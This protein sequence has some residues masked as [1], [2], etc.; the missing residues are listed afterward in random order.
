M[1]AILQSL[2]SKRLSFS[3]EEW[4]NYYLLV[5]NNTTFLPECFFFALVQFF[6]FKVHN[7]IS[8]NSQSCILIL[9]LMFC[10]SFCDVDD[11]PQ[12]CKISKVNL[13]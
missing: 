8:K 2:V 5:K 10:K 4:L 9:F 11:Q 13:L 6:F 1:Q 7:T 12:E 3:I